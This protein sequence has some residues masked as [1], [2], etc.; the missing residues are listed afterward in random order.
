MLMRGCVCVAGNKHCC[1]KMSR[2]CHWYWTQHRNRFGVFAVS[3]NYAISKSLIMC[4]NLRSKIFW[5]RGLNSLY[6]ALSK[7]ADHDLLEY[8]PMYF[9]HYA[10]KKWIKCLIGVYIL[11]VGWSIL[12]IVKF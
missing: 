4:I 7:N 1:W 10:K 11:S 5:Y 2:S 8:V 6:F 9:M 12:P 3:K